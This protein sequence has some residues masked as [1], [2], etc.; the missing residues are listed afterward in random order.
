MLLERLAA[1]GDSRKVSVRE[2]LREAKR[3]LGDARTTS[4]REKSFY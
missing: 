2:K 4:C 3:T 1:V